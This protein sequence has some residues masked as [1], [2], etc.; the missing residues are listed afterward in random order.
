MENLEG[1]GGWGLDGGGMGG[2]IY[3]ELFNELLLTACVGWHS[4]EKCKC[5]S[6]R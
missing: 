2:A 5:G 1:Q 3:G 6:K 4:A